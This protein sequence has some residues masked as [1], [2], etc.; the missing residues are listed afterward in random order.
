MSF[1]V[2][3]NQMSSQTGF[4]TISQNLKTASINAYLL[5]LTTK[6]IYLFQVHLPKEPYLHTTAFSHYY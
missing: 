2:Q 6:G 3:P 1:S 5:A 4:S